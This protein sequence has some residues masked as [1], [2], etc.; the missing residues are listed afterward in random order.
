MNKEGLGSNNAEKIVALCQFIT[1]ELGPFTDHKAVALATKEM[2]GHL[3]RHN[4]PMKCGTRWEII[5]GT[6]VMLLE[7]GM[8]I[9]STVWQA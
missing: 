9:D 2:E 8:P 5:S 1:N 3:A 6:L 7:D 4:D